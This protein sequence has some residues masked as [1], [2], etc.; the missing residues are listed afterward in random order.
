M[1]PKHQVPSTYEF[2]R[3]HPVFRLEEFAAALGPN[4][5]RAARERLKYH[6][7][8]GRVKLLERGLYASVPAGIDT[9]RYRPDRFLA[10]AA[11][12]PEGILSHHAALE[13]LGAAHSVWNVCTVLTDRRR[14]PLDLDNAEV[15]FLGHPAPLRR[16]GQHRLGSR[17]IDYQGARLTVT[18]PERTLVDGFHQPR[19]AGGLAELV[20]S[21]SGFGVLDLKLLMA[22]LD[23]YDLKTLCAAVGWFLDRF[24]ETFF[25]P[26]QLLRDLRERRPRSPTYLP[27]SFRGGALVPE[28]N[29]VLPQAVLRL[30]EP[31]AD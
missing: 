18:G 4:A 3:A 23:A 9:E 6:A 30:S 14:R 15:R 8:Q 2:L 5:T 17:R 12:R 25:V 26:D 7:G 27:S 19:W 24:R 29:L 21:A 13:L 31:D 1:N 20:E 16:N 28:W 22:V 11:L 10:A